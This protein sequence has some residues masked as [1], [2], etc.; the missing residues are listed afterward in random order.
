VGHFL[1][2]KKD[3]LHRAGRLNHLLFEVRVFD[4]VFELVLEDSEAWCFF[5]LE[6]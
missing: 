3:D 2:K 4:P 6:V 1:Y 5:L